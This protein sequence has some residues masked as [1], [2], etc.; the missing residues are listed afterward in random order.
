MLQDS[1]SKGPHPSI[2]LPPVQ[3]RTVT[4]EVL[5]RLRDLLFRGILRPGAR[6]DQAEL[7][8]SFGVSTVPVREA[9]LRL[10]SAGLVQVV[11]HRGVF[12]SEVSVAELVDIYTT[13]ELL[14]E[15]AARLSVVHLTAEDM[16][17]L[18]ETASAMQSA[19]DKQQ[20]DELLAL[21]REFHFT[22]YRAAR[23]RHLLH[24]IEQ[25]WD[26]STRY[27]HLQLH[28]V[29]DRASEALY[30]IRSILS[31]GKRRDADALG[32]MIRY[33]VHQTTVGL[34]QHM[35]LPNTDK[36]TEFLEKSAKKAPGKAAKARTKTGKASAAKTRP[37]K[38]SAA[39]TKTAKAQPRGQGRGAK[40]KGKRGT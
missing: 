24:L 37:A 4:E 27:A 12:V 28:A 11:S 32:L 38:P 18:E 5:S 36:T 13:R 21:N 25:L 9:L 3:R 22:I 7:A 14:E 6:I 15:Q 40:V 29:P 33:K 1:A 35:N 30:E 31:A 26:L 10:Q 34:M 39:K 2:P 17:F 8:K 20:L 23:R 16:E 19:A